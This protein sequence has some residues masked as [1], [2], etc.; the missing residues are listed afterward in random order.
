MSGGV[1]IASSRKLARRSSTA[2]TES[3]SAMRGGSAAPAFTRRTTVLPVT[4][5]M[6]HSSALPGSALATTA[7]RAVAEPAE[8]GDSFS[9][10]ARTSVPSTCSTT[11]ASKPAADQLAA[12]PHQR[13]TDRGWRGGR[14]NQDH[15]RWRL[16][17]GRCRC[18]RRAGQ[19]GG[20][21]DD[22]NE[23]AAGARDH[24]A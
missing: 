9:S 3:T 11:S 20:E 12:Q 2:R 22:R 19:Q 10:E 21:H 16:R 1:A 17:R 8:A 15:L 4:R 24:R 6:T 23:R 14:A 13:L 5:S 18:V 7:T